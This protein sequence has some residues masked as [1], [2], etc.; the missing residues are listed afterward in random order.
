M[1]AQS[2]PEAPVVAVEALIALGRDQD[3]RTLL[4][5]ADNPS[6]VLSAITSWNLGRSEDALTKIAT[7]GSNAPIA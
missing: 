4:E 6:D 1:K 2:S 7:V 5:A 3:A